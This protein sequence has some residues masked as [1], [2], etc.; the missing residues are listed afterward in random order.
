MKR[1]IYC[2]GRVIPLVRLCQACHRRQPSVRVLQ[3]EQGETAGGVS[4][5]AGQEAARPS[6]R[7][8]ALPAEPSQRRLSRRTMLKVAGV[9]GVGIGVGMVGRE[10]YLLAHIHPLT[11]YRGHNALIEAVAW[12][13][14]SRWIASTSGDDAQVWE[15]FSGR[16]L[17]RF[18]DERGVQSAAWSPDGAYLATGSWDGTASM[19]EMA[20]GHQVLTYRGH[21]SD[22]SSS[23]VSSAGLAERTAHPSLRPAS[24][25]ASGI[26]R[27]AWSP[28]GTR[29]ISSGYNRTA[30]VWE[31][32][33]GKTLLRF[34]DV[35]E[36]PGY[37]EEETWSSDGQHLL[38]RT[39]SGIEWHL[40]TTGALEST[41][42]IGF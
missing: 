20:T 15:A 27:L 36:Y 6:E 37:Y 31:A 7:Q 25:R 1:C 32:L 16:L 29:L 14:D 2:Q 42:S 13:P 34:G 28:D 3:P 38:M 35:L 9:A 39:N 22:Q 12:S 8:Q 18:P 4:S 24:G 19:W 21:L 23:R 11:T 17:H 26:D 5:N 30:R 33:T 40:A 10:V 41:F